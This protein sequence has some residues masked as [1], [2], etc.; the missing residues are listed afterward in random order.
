MLER[1][2]AREACVGPAVTMLMRNPC[3]VQRTKS[4]R[5]EWESEETGYFVNR[6]F[7]LCARGSVHN[8]HVVGIICSDVSG[9]RHLGGC[10]AP[11]R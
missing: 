9:T 4:V 8:R 1:I 7:L 2:L 5:T 11:P 6:F 3:C 10:H